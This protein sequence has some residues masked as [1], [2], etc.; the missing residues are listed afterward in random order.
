MAR[1]LSK[2]KISDR[3]QRKPCTILLTPCEFLQFA[4]VDPETVGRADPT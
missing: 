2:D 4:E 3:G 1:A